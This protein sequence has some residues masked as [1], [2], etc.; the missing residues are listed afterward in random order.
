MSETI[1]TRDTR[2]IV[3]GSL[4][5]L[6]GLILLLDRLDLFYFRWNRLFWI[7]AACLGG[8]FV[9]DGF[10]RK[11]RGRVFW[12][13]MMFFVSAYY[14]MLQW[15]IIDRYSF[16]TVPAFLIAIGLS[17]VMLYLYEPREVALLI[18]A[19][20]FVGTGTAAILWW[21]EVIDWWDVRHAIRTYWPLLLVF[22]GVGLIV[23]R[24]PQRTGTAELPPEPPQSS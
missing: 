22:L 4:L 9:V 20:L 11:L 13:S 5:I 10:L 1:R 2:A 23:R 15:R 6:V 7:V 8:F 17:L 12:G 14:I 16:Y 18:P 3:I 19:I 21:W 24:K